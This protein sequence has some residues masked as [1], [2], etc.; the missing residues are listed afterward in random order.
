M[1]NTLTCLRNIGITRSNAFAKKMLATHAVNCGLICGH[2]CKYCST[3]ALVRT[4][5]F[6]KKNKITS[7]AALENGEAVLDLWTHIRI[8]RQNMKLTKT[9]VVMMST[10]TDCWSP[11]AQA[12]N[13]GRDILS[14][15]LANSSC[16]VRIL[17]KNASIIKD[18][19]LIEKY[20]DRIMLGLSITAPIHKEHIVKVLEPHAS[21]ISERFQAMYIAR[22][23]GI[24]TYGMICPVLPGIGTSKY[25][26]E[27]MFDAVLK[28]N[29][30]TIWTEPLNPRGPGIINCVKALQSNG[31]G[32]IASDFDL[33]RSASFHQPYVEDLINT[34]TNTAISRNYLN[35]LK[36]LVFSDGN[37]YNVNDAAVIWLKR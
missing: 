27:S 26:Y 22:D 6:F 37:G 24:R 32:V 28:A 12:H 2:G 15:I 33:I 11:E 23:M 5:P 36:I 29:P 16:Q 17:T 31:F 1:A 4:H 8:Q 3:P 14:I 25:D 7:F 10:I 20:R 21:S 13:V 18:F 19:D 35:K 9:D 30:E 34:A